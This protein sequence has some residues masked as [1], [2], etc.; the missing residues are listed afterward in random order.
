MSTQNRYCPVG[1]PLYTTEANV[2]FD[3]G[4]QRSFITQDLVNKLQ[5]NTTRKVFGTTAPAIREL[6]VVTIEL[7][8]KSNETVS[9]DALVVPQIATALQNHLPS[10]RPNLRY[11]DG[12]KVAHSVTSDTQFEIS[13]L[14]G[15]DYYW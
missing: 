12:L 14:I 10:I 9:L 3:E 7:V 2:L 6:E 11:L 15:V 4:A 5:F 1:S 8:T 13:L